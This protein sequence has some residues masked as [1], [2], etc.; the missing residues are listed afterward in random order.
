MQLDFEK[1]LRHYIL[2]CWGFL[3]L[4]HLIYLLENE[5]LM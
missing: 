5:H 2:T 1:S 3:E 4:P